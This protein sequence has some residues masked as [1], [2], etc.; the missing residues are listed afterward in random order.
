M[1]IHFKV[2]F[3]F[4]KSRPIKICQLFCISHNL[5]N[6]LASTAPLLYQLTSAAVKH[7]TSVLA[8]RD[9]APQTWETSHLMDKLWKQYQ[10]TGLYF[11]LL[12]L[13]LKVSSRITSS[14]D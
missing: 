5:R 7:F 6:G 9:V 14:S 1:D 8:I 4:T 13:F 11:L 2:R 3:G 12:F 10:N